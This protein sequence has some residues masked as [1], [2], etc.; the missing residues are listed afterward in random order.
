MVKTLTKDKFKWPRKHEDKH[1]NLSHQQLEW[2]LSGY[3]IIGHKP[4]KFNNLML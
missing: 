1:L 4:L 3:D 2:L